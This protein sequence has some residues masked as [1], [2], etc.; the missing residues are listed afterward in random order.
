MA[1]N[2]GYFSDINIKHIKGVFVC[3]EVYLSMKTRQLN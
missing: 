1:V 3:L 2:A